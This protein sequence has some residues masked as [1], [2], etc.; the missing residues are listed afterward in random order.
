[1]KPKHTKPI[2][3]ELFGDNPRLRFLDFIIK[4]NAEDFNMTTIAKKSKISYNSLRIF[5]DY[6]LDKGIVI[7]T[8]R[9]GKSDMYKLNLKNS[10]SKGLIKFSEFL[11][12]DPIEPT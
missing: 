2:F 4:N 8:R 6:F 5:F 12:I 11:G 9:I 10:I 1:M 3:S 7:K